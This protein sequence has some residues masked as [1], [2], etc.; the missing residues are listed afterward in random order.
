MKNF[1]R[2]GF[3]HLNGMF[4]WIS[5]FE[6]LANKWAAVSH[7]IR[8]A[9]DHGLPVKIWWI[10]LEMFFIEN[11]GVPPANIGIYKELKKIAGSELEFPPTEKKSTHSMTN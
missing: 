11:I 8:E 5:Y 7:H 4:T 2:R 3:T 9:E 1:F 10:H 6:K